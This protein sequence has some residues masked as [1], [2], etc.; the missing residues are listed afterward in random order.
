MILK[1]LLH[2][3]WQDIAK[4]SDKQLEE[5]CK[6]YFHV[7]RPEEV[8]K[9]NN[10]TSLMGVIQARAAKEAKT[11]SPKADNRKA[12]YEEAKRR[13]AQMGLPLE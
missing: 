7:T 9:Q 12:L 10:T 13:F 5:L 6:P 11:F 3:P 1:D 2:C 4:L 8:K